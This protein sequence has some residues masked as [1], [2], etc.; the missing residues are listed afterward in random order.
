VNGKRNLDLCI[1][2]KPTH[3]SNFPAITS[4]PKALAGLSAPDV[5]GVANSSAMNKARPIPTGARNVDLFVI[6]ETHPT[7]YTIDPIMEGENTHLCF[8]AANMR[9]ANI[10]MLVM[11]IS[12]K[13]PWAMD[14]PP[15]SRDRAFIPPGS[16]TC[17]I[18]AL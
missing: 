16:R 12:I 6:S 10:N 1:V 4:G 5:K 15:D 2:E 9:M 13:N 7:L 18:P 14:V 17:A 3:P 8:S 11:N